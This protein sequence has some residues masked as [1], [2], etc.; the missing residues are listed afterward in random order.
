MACFHAFHVWMTP[1][2]IL[3]TIFTPLQKFNLVVESLCVNAGIT[4]VTSSEQVL[5]LV[6]VPIGFLELEL[7]QNH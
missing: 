6:L 4:L 7:K 5:I 3:T 2:I 1:Q